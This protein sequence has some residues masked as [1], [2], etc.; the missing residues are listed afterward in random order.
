MAARDS[1]FID[2]N[3][4]SNTKPEFRQFRRQQG[5]IV[6]YPQSFEITQ[7]EKRFYTMRAYNTNLSKYVTWEVVNEPDTT[8]D[9]SGYPVIDLQDIGVVV[10]DIRNA[11]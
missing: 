2:S 6:W 5:K 4:V 1:F 3:V 10:V 11:E 9:F 7:L 8:G